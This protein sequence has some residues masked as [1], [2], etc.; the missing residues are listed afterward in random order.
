[1]IRGWLEY[2]GPKDGHPVWEHR[3]VWVD[4]QLR[5]ND[6]GEI[7]VKRN[8][9]I[10]DPEDGEQ[11]NTF[12]YEEGNYACDCNRHLFFHRA[13][14]VEPDDERPCGD[15]A[16]SVNLINPKDGRV[17]YR[18]FDVAPTSTRGDTNAR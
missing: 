9:M 6:S 14:G 4:V 11:P 17:F 10:F 13:N 15:T 1:M 7:R 12:M 5:R 16:Y 8:W 3:I 18:E 2:D